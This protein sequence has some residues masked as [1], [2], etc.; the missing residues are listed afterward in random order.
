MTPRRCSL[1][2]GLVLCSTVACSLVEPG[3]GATL[4][5]FSRHLE[6][7]EIE[8]AQNLLS[9][10]TLEQV[11]AAKLRT[12]LGGSAR[13]I[14]EKQG[15]DNIEIQDEEIQGELAT[16]TSVVTFGDGSMSTQTANFINEQGQWKIDLGGSK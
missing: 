11:G 12:L 10:N 1:A 6:Q 13:D 15:I 9:S 14:T 7:G 3:P 16:A 8:D 2:L 4:I 5:Q